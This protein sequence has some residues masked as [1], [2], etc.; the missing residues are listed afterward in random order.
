MSVR[1]DI[2]MILVV[3]GGAFAAVL[4]FFYAVLHG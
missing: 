1:D 4:A 3:G 2:K